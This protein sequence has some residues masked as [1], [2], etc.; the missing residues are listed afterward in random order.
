MAY[1]IYIEATWS[2]Q[3]GSG[4]DT[5]RA[6]GDSRTSTQALRVS[7]ISFRESEDT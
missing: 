1:T 4:A 3:L 5:E 7:P 2:L 6:E